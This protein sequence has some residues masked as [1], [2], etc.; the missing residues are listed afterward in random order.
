MEGLGLRRVGLGRV[1]WV[2]PPAMTHNDTRRGL[3]AAG[4]VCSPSVS[5]F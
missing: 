3:D 4:A 5:R 2:V 1:E